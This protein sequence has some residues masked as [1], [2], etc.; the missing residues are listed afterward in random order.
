MSKTLLSTLAVMAI[1]TALVSSTAAVELKFEAGPKVGVNFADMWG[2]DANTEF[3]DSDIRI[4]LLGG[5]FGGVIITENFGARVEV[6]Y[7]QRGQ[8]ETVGTEEFTVKLDYFEIA[9][10][11][12]GTYPIN[13]QFS[14]QGFAG[15]YIGI[16]TLAEYAN[17]ETEDIG[18][19]VSSTDFGLGVGVG[20]SFWPNEMVRIFVN[21]QYNIGLTKVDDPVDEAVDPSDIKNHGV[22]ATV[23]AAIP[24]GPM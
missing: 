24:F 3:P 17:S 20:G 14:V 1:L 2:G 8:K 19:F 7:A 13:E 11:G 6:L 5:A 21:I 12:V 22:G 16:N 9:L 15:P 10:Y 23:G 4:G 18:D